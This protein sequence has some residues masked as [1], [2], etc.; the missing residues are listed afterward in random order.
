MKTLADGTVAYEVGDYVRVVYQPRHKDGIGWNRNMNSY[1]GK[2]VKITSSVF[3]H[4]H[5]EFCYQIDNNRRWTFVN[6]YFDGLANGFAVSSD[7][8]DVLLSDGLNDFISQFCLKKSHEAEVI[9]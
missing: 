5:G 7:I 2:I 8:E 3:N 6:E 1:C 9:L 4:G